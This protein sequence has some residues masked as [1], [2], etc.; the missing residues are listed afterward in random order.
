MTSAAA[1][2]SRGRRRLK[3]ENHPQSSQ[4]PAMLDERAQLLREH[5]A[6]RVALD[7]DAGAGP[8]R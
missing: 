7:H 5:D 8:S 1:L 2:F 6:G 3:F 4:P